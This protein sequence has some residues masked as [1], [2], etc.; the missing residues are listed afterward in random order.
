MQ[1]LPSLF[2]LFLCYSLSIW[3]MEQGAYSQNNNNVSRVQRTTGTPFS[4]YKNWKAVFTHLKRGSLHTE[5]NELILGGLHLYQN[6]LHQSKLGEF[7]LVKINHRFWIITKQ[8]PNTFHSAYVVYIKN[9]NPLELVLLKEIKSFFPCGLKDEKLVDFL[10]KQPFTLATQN[11]DLIYTTIPKQDEPR[12]KVVINQYGYVKTVYPCLAELPNPVQNKEL[13]NWLNH[14]LEQIKRIEPTL[15]TALTPQMRTQWEQA[16]AS[17]N[18]T[19]LERMLKAGVD[20]DTPVD[21]TYDSPLLIACRKGWFE[22]ASLFITTNADIDRL[23]KNANTALELAVQ[24]KNPDCVLIVLDAAQHLI[25]RVHPVLKIPLILNATQNCTPEIV[26]LLLLNGTEP[27]LA[28]EDG[29][30]ALHRAAK[31]GNSEMVKTLLCF[32]CDIEKMNKK[33]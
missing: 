18:S 2:S 10:K 6:P 15:H 26:R 22:L 28:D 23:D 25:N 1:F 9:Y 11:N 33:K 13:A 7:N 21:Q 3:G 24:S 32:A 5:N 20:P 31:S 12:I 17:Q 8:N 30:T 4:D 27:N 14:C 29:N 19:E 16:F